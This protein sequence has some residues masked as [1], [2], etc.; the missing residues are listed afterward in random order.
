MIVNRYNLEINDIIE[1][2]NKIVAA[3]DKLYF[4]REVPVSM[5]VIKNART[6]PYKYV[7]KYFDLKVNEN[8]IV[9]FENLYHG[10]YL[11]ENNIIGMN[12]DKAKLINTVKKHVPV[13]IRL[14]TGNFDEMIGLQNIIKSPKYPE[15]R[16]YYQ[17]NGNRVYK[18]YSVYFN[19]ATCKS[20][21]ESL[22]NEHEYNMFVKTQ[23]ALMTDKLRNAIKERDNYTCQICGASI[24]THP[25][26][27]FHIDHIIPVSK[28]GTTVEDNL[29]TLCSTCN[30]KKSNKMSSGDF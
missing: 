9:L 10:F 18:K 2:N 30:L 6:N 11:M 3:Q 17:S 25:N 26:I 14:L 16:F 27:L 23:R 29:Q 13:H 5:S 15:Y 22:K 21:L 1:T 20:F 19:S 8:F 4:Y 28:G 7:C 24:Y 12:R